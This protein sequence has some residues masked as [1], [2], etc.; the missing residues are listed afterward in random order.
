[1]TGST[2]DLPR[3]LSCFKIR[4]SV[5]PFTKDFAMH[6]TVVLAATFFGVI[7]SAIQGRAQYGTE[8]GIQGTG[9]ITLERT[10]E[11]MRM[12]VNVLAKS[13]KDLSDALTKLKAQRAKA[14]KQLQTL[15]AIKESVKFS[16]PHLDVSQDDTQR[17][18][19][20][21][22]RQRMAQRGK[23]RADKDAGTKII[24]VTMK[25]T[26][27][28]PLKAT[29][30]TGL[31]LEANKL[32]DAIKAADLGGA[33]DAEE[34]T[35]E[36]AEASEEMDNMQMNFGGQQ[37]PKPGEPEFI[38]LAK[39]A[40]ADREK[41]RVDAFKAAKEEAAQLAKSA[42]IQLGDLT[43]LS[44]QMSGA[45]IYGGDGDSDDV[46]VYYNR[47]MGQM[48]R[49]Y[50]NGREESSE[51]VGMTPGTL[52]FRVGITATFAIKSSAAGTK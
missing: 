22:M 11:R 48:F 2:M 36:E 31:L 32:Q 40:D 16:D 4:F 17:Q 13:S 34:P 12:Q 51:A 1:M 45:G 39:I 50:A 38:F 3:F 9:N 49:Q 14:E 26:A 25:L 20:M 41:A 30:P 10:A 27:E 43:R 37:G 33:K 24:K 42:D 47:G 18:M 29:D 52:K 28:R 19:Q 23:K 46:Q 7:V 6:R 35:P 21:M 5:V 44:K 15:G 8:D